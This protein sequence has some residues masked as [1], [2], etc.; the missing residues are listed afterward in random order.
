VYVT[1]QLEV[2]VALI[3][4]RLHVVDPNVPGPSLENVTVSCGH[5]FWP[6]SSSLTVAVQVVLSLTTTESGTQL[7][8]VLVSRLVTVTVKSSWLTACVVEPW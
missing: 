1:E 3:W 4:V 5:D 6:P 8:D 2:D 7:T